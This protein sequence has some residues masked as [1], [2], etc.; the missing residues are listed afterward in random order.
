MNETTSA[1]AVEVMVPE[2]RLAALEAAGERGTPDADAPALTQAVDASVAS[3]RGL[4]VQADAPD[5]EVRTPSNGAAAGWRC[6]IG[7]GHVPAIRADGS[8]LCS[9]C[10]PPYQQLTP[11]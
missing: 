3:V 6:S 5:A 7:P 8:L 2:Q 1:T 4:P 9:T 11:A 10:H